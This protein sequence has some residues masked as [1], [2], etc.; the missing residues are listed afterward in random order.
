MAEGNADD[1]GAVDDVQLVLIETQ[2][3]QAYIFASNRLREVVG[4]SELVHRFGTRWFLEALDPHGD[5]PDDPE[6]L[7]ARLCDPSLNPP[8]AAGSFEVV[9]AA[10]GKAMALA[11]SRQAGVAVVRAVAARAAVEAPGLSVTG[12]VVPARCGAAA[13]FGECVRAVHRRLALVRGRLPQPH[14]DLLRLPFT[15]DCG[16]TSLG[17]AGHDPLEPR[18]DPK[19]FSLPILMKRAARGGADRRLAAIA[20]PEA[21]RAGAAGDDALEDAAWLAVIHADG[22]GLGEVFNAFAARLPRGA[23]AEPG[24][25]DYVVAYRAFSFALD[26][27]NRRAVAAALETPAGR[28]P[29]RPLVVAGD[30]LTVV[31]RGADAMGFTARYL[32]AFER[33][34][35]Q[36]PA[37][38]ALMP[39]GIRAGAGVAIVKPHHP[40]HRA[41]ELAEALARSAKTV[42]GDGVSALDVHV[43]FDGASDLEIVRDRLRPRSGEELHG[44][45]YVLGALDGRRSIV[46]LAGAVAALAKPDEEEDAAPGLPRSQQHALRDAVMGGAKAAE[47]ARLRIHHRYPARDVWQTIAPSGGLFQQRGATVSTILIDA[48]ALA[49]VGASP[50]AVSAGV[51]S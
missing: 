42:K 34:S 4:A 38:T 40:F 19:P 35:R 5:W 44:G 11:P 50:F 27:V 46:D 14:A 51:P 25:R 9:I 12:A 6:A 20:G 32:D 26:R 36:E 28:V 31:C 37:I 13:A 45:P 23:G 22:N 7:A 41:Y 29:L 49:D 2:G 16:S 10:S 30:D 33:L 48:M 3:N 39:E 47:A 8:V 1:A 18:P 43:S 17:A 24:W 15:A 21:G